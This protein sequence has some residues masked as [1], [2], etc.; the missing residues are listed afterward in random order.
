MRISTRLER[1]RSRRR[2]VAGGQEVDDEAEALLRDAL[3]LVA[4][5]VLRIALVDVDQRGDVLHHRGRQ[6][7]RHRVPVP[8]HE[9]EGDD[10]LQDH[11]RHDHDEKRAGIEAG[12]HPALERVA[13]P[14]VRGGDAAR[15]ALE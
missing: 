10:R 15:R 5:F 11:H 1:L 7:A 4:I 3:D 6:A 9:H 8:L 13:H 14:A 2:H 12:R